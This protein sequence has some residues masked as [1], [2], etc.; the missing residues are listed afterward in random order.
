MG[1][2]KIELDIKPR[3]HQVC[4]QLILK[5]IKSPTKLHLHKGAIGVNGDLALEL[6]PPAGRVSR[7][8]VSAAPDLIRDLRQNPANYYVNVHSTQF[9]KGAVRGQL[10]WQSFSS[11]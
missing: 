5:G 1:S 11:W 9:P 3:H 10:G 2:G 4:Y 8:C 7:G 6:N